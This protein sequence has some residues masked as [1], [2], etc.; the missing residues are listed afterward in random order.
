MDTII[1]TN[2]ETVLKIFRQ[3]LNDSDH[4]QRT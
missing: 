2:F 3:S 1:S 4:A